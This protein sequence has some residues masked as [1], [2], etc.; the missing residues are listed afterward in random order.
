MVLV[1]PLSRRMGPPRKGVI[2]PKDQGRVFNHQG[3][4]AGKPLVF[5]QGGL[6]TIEDFNPILS[7]LG[8]DYCLI[9]IDSRG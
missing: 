2:M 1:I 7:E 4:P 9:G 6:G 3:A 5:L 8:K